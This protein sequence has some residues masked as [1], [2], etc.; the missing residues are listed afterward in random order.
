MLQ[1][2]AE[3]M[4]PIGYRKVMQNESYF[5]LYI[6]LQPVPSHPT[7]TGRF[8]ILGLCTLVGNF[9]LLDYVIIEGSPSQW[10]I[11]LNI[12]V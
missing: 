6:F 12:F 10:I 9:L 1:F 7:H 5:F 3:I 11:F 4:H 2:I 8:C